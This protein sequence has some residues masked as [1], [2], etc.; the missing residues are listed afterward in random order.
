MAGTPEQSDL[1]AAAA[2]LERIRAD[3]LATRPSDRERVRRKPGALPIRPDLTLSPVLTGKVGEMRLLQ[4]AIAQAGPAVYSA[5]PRDLSVL[6]T[7]LTFARGTLTLGVPDDATRFRVD[8]SLRAGGRSAI[9]AMM[10]APVRTIKVV[11]QH[12]DAR[13]LSLDDRRQ[14]SESD[15]EREAWDELPPP[16]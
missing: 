8:R 3:R 2:R 1:N 6:V 14:P 12:P 15:R 13:E 9:L 7:P 5:L 4:R 16:V 11:V 10:K